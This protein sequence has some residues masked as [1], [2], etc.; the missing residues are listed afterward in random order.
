MFV[1]AFR[2]VSSK[3]HFGL[4]DEFLKPTTTHMTAAFADA[5]FLHLNVLCANEISKP[6]AKIFGQSAGTEAPWQI[7]LVATRAAAARF[8]RMYSDAFRYHAATMSN[9]L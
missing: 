5:L 7:E 2:T 8:P 4:P 6:S 9:A 3:S 1:A